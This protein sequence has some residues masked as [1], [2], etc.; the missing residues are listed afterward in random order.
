[1][2]RSDLKK[3]GKNALVELAYKQH[4]DIENRK[5]GMR[6]QLEQI[7]AANAKLSD[8]R[9]QEKAQISRKSLAAGLLSAALKGG[10]GTMDV[11]E[12]SAWAFSLVDELDKPL[13]EWYKNNSNETEER[14]SDTLGATRA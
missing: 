5:V 4:V 9:D 14:K 7:E 1:M 10:E 13:A 12:L 2:E 6:S 3:M 8:L 11:Q